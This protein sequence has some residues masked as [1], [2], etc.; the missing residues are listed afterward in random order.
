MTL[1]F[2]TLLITMSFAIAPLAAVF[3]IDTLRRPPEGSGRYWALAFLSALLCSIAYFISGHTDD[4]W[5]S[6][7]AGNA[8]MVFTLGALW[9]GCRAFNRRR[10]FV[11]LVVGITLTVAVASALPSAEGSKWAG[12]AEKMLALGLFSALVVVECLRPRL[13]DFAGAWLLAAVLAVHAVYVVARSVTYLAV[14]HEH[15]VFLVWFGTGF[16]TAMNLVL[17]LLGGL[18]TIAIRIQAARRPLSRRDADG[19]RRHLENSIAFRRRASGRLAALQNDGQGA[20][21][22]VL[23]IDLFPQLR[24]A[25]GAAHA[26]GLQESLARAVI[27][28]AHSDAV[29][30]RLLGD[31]IAALLPSS[32]DGVA[33]ARGF[34]E[35]VQ[36][37]YAAENRS[38]AATAVSAGIAAAHTRGPEH[39]LDLD[40]LVDAACDALVFDAE[41]GLGRIRVAAI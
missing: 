23:A 1:D 18:A 10:A 30:G 41:A 36:A 32:P 25:Y 3:F 13:R 29:V 28:H 39:T 33:S 8:A 20:V 12:A 22:V 27:T 24:G 37:E 40:L 7:A 6:V 11:L 4:V 26:T 38:A 15:P 31:A 17:V 34:A 5:W 19:R 21:L 2:S 35:A 9:L 14:G 16:V